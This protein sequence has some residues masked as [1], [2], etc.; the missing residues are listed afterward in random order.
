MEDSAA[1]FSFARGARGWSGVPVVNITV[2]ARVAFDLDRMQGIIKQ[3]AA[4]LGHEPC[5][6]GFDFRFQQQLE[7]VADQE[8]RVTPRG[9]G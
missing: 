5:H 2:P 4:E 7:F 8:G 6:S 9:L 3:V 1:R